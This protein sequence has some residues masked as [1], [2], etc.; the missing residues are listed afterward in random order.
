MLYF[1]LDGDVGDVDV[2]GGEEKAYGFI[3]LRR[4][5]LECVRHV[6]HVLDSNH[7]RSHESK[8]TQNLPTNICIF[9]FLN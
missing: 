4:I 7:V 9:L 6:R 2:D 5:L 3:Y 8:N 1:L